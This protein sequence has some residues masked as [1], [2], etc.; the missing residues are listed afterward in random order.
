MLDDHTARP[1][2]WLNWSRPRPEPLSPTAAALPVLL[3]WP[4]FAGLVWLVNGHE[5]V[6][7]TTVG[8][9]LALVNDDQ[10]R[11]HLRSL[12]HDAR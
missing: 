12:H 4:F 11:A 10:V 9:L 3:L 8:L 7:A 1:V 5:P 2:R 6:T